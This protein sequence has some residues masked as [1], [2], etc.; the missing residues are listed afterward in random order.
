MKKM[1]LIRIQLVM[2]LMN[3]KEILRQILL[4]LDLKKKQ[5]MFLIVISKSEFRRI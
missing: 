4:K 5:K 1:T 3:F 2:N